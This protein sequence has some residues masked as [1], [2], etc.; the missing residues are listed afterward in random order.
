[1]QHVETKQEINPVPARNYYSCQ[2]NDLDNPVPAI[3]FQPNNLCP[4]MESF[5]KNYE[6]FLDKLII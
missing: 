3:S 1:M 2:T 4:A 5:Y 6:W